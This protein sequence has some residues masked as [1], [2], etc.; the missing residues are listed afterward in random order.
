M[1]GKLFWIV[2]QDNTNIPS[3]PTP[4]YREYRYS[5][6]ENTLMFLENKPGTKNEC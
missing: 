4:D 3:T 6:S 2:Y 5:L 1:G